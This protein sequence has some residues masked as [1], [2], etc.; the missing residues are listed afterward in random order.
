MAIIEPNVANVFAGPTVLYLAPAHTAPPSLASVPS[1]NQWTTAGFQPCG[2]TEDGWEFVTTP[3]VKDFTP[4]E[5]IS[6]IIQLVTGIKVE[7]KGTLWE[8]T[9]ENLS[10]AIALATLSDPALGIKTLSV[11][12]GNPLAEYALGFQGP[13]PGGQTD[14]V[15]NVWRV[16]VTSA[17][18]QKYQRKDI[19]KLA[20][21]F[22]A[23]TDS[24]KPA[25]S[26]VYQVVDFNAGS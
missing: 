22:T 21:T 4:D 24:T 26:D 25:G 9:L 15:I 16:N 2:Y 1:A 6:P 11:G 23:L 3:S 7:I 12:S 8:N 17:I 10:K 20:C 14:R 5:A 13:A 19:S 18:S